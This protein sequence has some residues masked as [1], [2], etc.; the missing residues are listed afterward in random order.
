GGAGG[1]GGVELWWSRALPGPGRP[2]AGGCRPNRFRW[3]AAAGGRR[4]ASGGSGA[5]LPD[6]DSS[7]VR[8]SAVRA[9]AFAG[10][11]G[12]RVRPRRATGGGRRGE[13][14]GVARW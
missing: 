11:T 7:R 9:P 13:R 8:V 2:G 14:G 6:G 1:G 12:S 5:A 4:G 3:V 10:A